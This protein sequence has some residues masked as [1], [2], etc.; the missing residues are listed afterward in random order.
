MQ[1]VYDGQDAQRT[2]VRIGLSSVLK[3]L[4]QPTDIQFVPGSSTQVVICEKTGK[5]RFFDLRKKTSSVI[6]NYKVHKVSELGVLGLAFHPKFPKVSKVYLNY[7]PDDHGPIRTRISE[8]DWVVGRGTMAG[9]RVLLE[10]NQPYSN[11]NAG[12]LAFGPDGLLYIGLGDGG[13]GGDPKKNGQNKGALLGKMLRINVDKKSPR[14]AYSIPSDNPFVNDKAFRPEIFAW[15]LRNPWRY[16][17]DPAGRLVVAD[18]GQNL[19]EEVSIVPKGGNMGWVTME[20]NHCFEPS[21]GCKTEGLIPAV[22]EYG[23]DDGGSI[24][25]GFVYL[26]SSVPELKDLYVFGDF[27]SGRMW[28]IKL[29]DAIPTALPV[30]TAEMRTLGRWPMALSTFGRDAA[31]EIYVADFAGGEVYSISAVK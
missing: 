5:V 3:G 20:S 11:H 13:S 2:K 23:R 22:A 15:G 21:T 24:T 16:T 8:F 10:V 17:F 14:L 12:Q 19:W 9:E 25:G 6:G 7:N 29:P 27:A 18:V 4:N 31:G 1:P 28:A 30:K 26:G